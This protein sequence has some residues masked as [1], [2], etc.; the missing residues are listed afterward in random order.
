MKPLLTNLK[1]IEQQ[2]LKKE[3]FIDV[4][5][6]EFDP[7]YERKVKEISKRLGEIVVTINEALEEIKFTVEELKE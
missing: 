4:E 2:L 3:H 7:I 6:E 1:T 5:E